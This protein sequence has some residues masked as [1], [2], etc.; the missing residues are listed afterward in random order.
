MRKILGE[1]GQ[2]RSIE[3]MFAAISQTQF[4]QAAKTHRI[5]VADSCIGRNQ[6]QIRGQMINSIGLLTKELEVLLT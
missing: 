5:N 6:C 1:Y 2:G 3:Q 4:Q